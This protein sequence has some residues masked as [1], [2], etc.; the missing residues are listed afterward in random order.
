MLWTGRVLSGLSALLFL[1]S[2]INVFTKSP[3][4]MEGMTHLG[5]PASATPIIGI[6]ALVSAILYAVPRT[7]VLG[8]ILLTGYLGGAVA[9]HL[10]VGDPP[11]GAVIFGVLVWGGLYLR[12]KRVR[13]LLPLRNRVQ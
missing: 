2:G 3:M 12:D 4:V 11:V 5:Y 10:R 6:A 9:S 1:S 7:A 8:A 13:E